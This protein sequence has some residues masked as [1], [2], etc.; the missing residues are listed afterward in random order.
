MA[1]HHLKSY[2]SICSNIAQNMPSVCTWQW[3][4][5]FHVALSVF[6]EEHVESILSIVSKEFDQQYN[7]ITAED[8]TDTEHIDKFV[9]PLFGIVP[10]QEIFV[11]ENGS[12]LILFAIW[13]P[14]GNGKTTSLRIGIISTEEQSLNKDEIKGYLTEWFSIE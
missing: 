10:G 13:W 12:G 4:E 5:E 14:W 8:D 7:S 3:D 11:S 6:E 9:V 2:E 1:S